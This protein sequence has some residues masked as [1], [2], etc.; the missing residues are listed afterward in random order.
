MLKAKAMQS[1]IIYYLSTAIGL[2]SGGSVTKIGRTY[3]N[4]HTRT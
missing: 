4:G 2:M 3:K 1:F